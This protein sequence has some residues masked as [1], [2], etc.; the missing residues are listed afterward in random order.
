M[1]GI[2]VV[3]DQKDCIAFFWAVACARLVLL[4]FYTSRCVPPVV[5]R[6]LMLRIM[7][8]LNQRDSNVAKFWRT[9]LLCTTTGAH[10]QTAQTV[11][12]PQLQSIQVVDISFEVQRQSL[13]VQTF[14]QTIDFLQLLYKVVDVSVSRSSRFSSPSWRRGC[15]LWSR[16]LVGPLRLRSCSTRRMVDV[17][18]VRSHSP[19]VQTWRR[20]LSSHSCARLSA[21]TLSCTFSPLCNDRCWVVQTSQLL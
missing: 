5:V 14:R 11:E 17:P 3:M 13:T 7:V 15:F 18:V 16:P 21:W 8:G 1:L 12:S 2:M 4:V 9:F 20:Q 10:V 6:P 19:R